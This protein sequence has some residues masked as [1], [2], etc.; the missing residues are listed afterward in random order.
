MNCHA[1]LHA[2]PIRCSQSGRQHSVENSPA[3]RSIEWVHTSL[4]VTHRCGWWWT[5]NRGSSPGAWGDYKNGSAAVLGRPSLDN[6]S[7]YMSK[8]NVRILQEGSWSVMFCHNCLFFLML[9]RTAIRLWKCI[10][11]LKQ[12]V[13]SGLTSLAGVQRLR[14]WL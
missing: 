6:V 5:R 1:S 4:S 9:F 14:S 7:A 10:S 2:V 11:C 12:Y 13:S 8:N 3:L